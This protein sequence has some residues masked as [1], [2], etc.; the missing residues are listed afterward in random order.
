MYSV[1]TVCPYTRMKHRVCPLQQAWYSMTSSPWY[2]LHSTYVPRIKIDPV[3]SS[4][5]EDPG[6][7]FP[8]NVARGQ[9]KSKAR[10]Q[11]RGKTHFEYLAYFISLLIGKRSR[12]VEKRFRRPSCEAP[13]FYKV[14]QPG[15]PDSKTDEPKHLLPSPPT[16]SSLSTEVPWPSTLLSIVLLS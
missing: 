15:E 16:I 10:Q 8:I 2:S 11:A 9:A 14:Q 7:S 13:R 6:L 3:G 1:R 4:I 5:V 12:D